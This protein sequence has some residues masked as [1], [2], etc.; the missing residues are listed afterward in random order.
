MARALSAEIAL[1][2][3]K[4]LDTSAKQERLSNLTEKIT[5]LSD[6]LQSSAEKALSSETTGY[7]AKNSTEITTESD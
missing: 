7:C 6:T 4:G 2:K 1:D 5:I 3:S